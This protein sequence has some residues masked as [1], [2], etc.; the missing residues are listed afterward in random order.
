M[1][2]L[3]ILESQHF[4]VKEVNP[5]KGMG[6]SWGKSPSE[7]PYTLMMNWFMRRQIKVV[8]IVL[9]LGCWHVALDAY[10][11]RFGKH[12]RQIMPNEDGNRRYRDREAPTQSALIAKYCQNLT[13][14][15]VRNRDVFEEDRGDILSVLMNNPN[16]EVLHIEGVLDGKN[17]PTT[18]PTLSLPRLKQLKWESRHGF[19]DSL[20][21]LAEAAPNLQQLMLVSNPKKC[22]EIDG[23]LMIEV[24]HACPQLCTLSC[25][26]L[27][28]GRNDSFLSVF[29]TFCSD[30][31]NLD[32][33]GHRKLND[34]MLIDA[35]TELKSLNSL[36]LRGC[37]RLTDKTLQFLA[38]RYAG[39]LN[40][41]YLDHSVFEKYFSDAGEDEVN[42][43]V[44]EEMKRGIGGYTAAGI[45][46]LRAQCTHLYT[47]HY[48]I[49]AGTVAMPQHIEAYQNATIVHLCAQRDIVLPIMLEHCQQM[50]ILAMPYSQYGSH[51][52]WL[53][54]EQLMTIVAC[55]PLLRMIVSEKNTYF[56]DKNEVD[57]SPVRRAFP[58]LRFVEDMKVLDFDALELL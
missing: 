31:V 50:Q 3:D 5:T 13:A 56:T 45:A 17:N 23:S 58:K 36:D 29:L 34:T 4:Y 1:Q 7:H 21:A 47:Y 15:F 44:R 14:Y 26:E 39:T 19:D 43:V 51:R 2:L 9:N 48:T 37:C 20:V 46:S 55:C 18:T 57:Y 33:R 8:S 12:V 10:L 38:H 40:V 6:V 27:Y 30:I 25:K 35:L 32:I 41:L 53:T 42:E 28:L 54:V 52:V 11:K 49:Q 22:T 16:Q 24:A